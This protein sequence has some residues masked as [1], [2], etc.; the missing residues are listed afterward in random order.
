MWSWSSTCAFST[1]S[2]ITH[3]PFMIIPSVTAM[4]SL[5]DPYSVMSCCTW[6][7]ISSQPTMIYPLSHCKCSSCTVACCVCAIDMHSAMFID[8]C[9]VS[10]LMSMPYISPS[11]FS[12]TVPG[13]PFC[14]EQLWPQLVYYS[15]P[16]LVYPLE[17]ATD[18]L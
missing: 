11:L 13:Q 14:N 1:Y 16:V 3:P 2:I 4:S 15:N 6:S 9:I 7:L 5:N 8:A 10:T 17:N 18:L 12:V